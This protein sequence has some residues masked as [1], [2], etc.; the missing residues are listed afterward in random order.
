MS[1]IFLGD[2][3]I[4]G[5]V[6]AT[7]AGSFSAGD[8]MVLTDSGEVRSAADAFAQLA[9]GEKFRLAAETSLEPSVS[10]YRPASTFSQ[11]TIGFFPNGNFYAAH[12]GYDSSSGN[13]TT[14]FYVFDS[15]DLSVLDHVSTE[16]GS[17]S[18]GIIT[19]NSSKFADGS[20]VFIYSDNNN[21]GSLPLIQTL[22][23]PLRSPGGGANNFKYGLDFFDSAGGSFFGMSLSPYSLGSGFNDGGYIPIDFG[24]DS[25]GRQYVLAATES[26]TLS[27]YNSFEI[28]VYVFQNGSITSQALD[29]DSIKFDGFESRILHV[30]HPAVV[31]YEELGE[32]KT[33]FWMFFEP[34]GS[35]ATA[36]AK[37]T[38]W[39]VQ[40]VAIYDSAG[41]PRFADL[42][43]L[44]VPSSYFMIHDDPGNISNAKFHLL[45]YD[46]TGTYLYEIDILNSSSSIKKNKIFDN[47]YGQG[48]DV[49]VP[50]V[51]FGSNLMAAVGIDE[52]PDGAAVKIIDYKQNPGVIE[53]EYQFLNDNIPG[54]SVY[55]DDD[56]YTLQIAAS[57]R[58]EIG[59]SYY[60]NTYFAKLSPNLN[61]V[62]FAENSGT[63]GD[64]VTI[65]QPEQVTEAVTGFNQ[66]DEIRMRWDGTLSTEA[67][68]PVGEVLANGK[69]K[70]LEGQW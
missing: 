65:A 29:S 38:T 54:Y 14:D 57:N 41:N 56:L 50:F 52:S 24:F 60:Y 28:I 3:L 15:K 9:A 46:G 40:P 2:T 33:R 48:Y 25:A 32:R 70:I 68:I 44:A 55:A 5:S 58:D 64:D 13:V 30:Q 31:Q 19:F 22:N 49:G 7:S 59:I 26:E 69:V 17:T 63:T 36:P 20:T 11:E 1:K 21:T 8:P 42:Q 51:P 16:P 4:S 23:G 47:H 43:S 6:P 10:Q 66:G 61:F 62:G 35:E 18:S 12:E 39:E 27:G 45:S 37:G 34:N 53:A 67:G